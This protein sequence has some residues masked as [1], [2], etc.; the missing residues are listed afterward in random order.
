MRT[1]NIIGAAVVT[2]GLSLA[3]A[4]TVQD[5]AR[6]ELGTYRNAQNEIC[7]T[8][9][10]K[11]KCLSEKAYQKDQVMKERRAGSNREYL[12]DRVD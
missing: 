12:H 7:Q 11:E 10:G 1:R 2:M 5:Q 3:F 4:S 8:T 9:N 6:Q